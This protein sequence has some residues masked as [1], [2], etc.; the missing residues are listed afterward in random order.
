MGEVSDADVFQV[1][2]IIPNRV[3]FCPCHEDPSSTDEVLRFTIDMDSFYS[4]H[5]FLNEF[6]PPSIAQVHKFFDMLYYLLEDRPELIHYFCYDDAYKFTTA[7]CLICTFQMIYTGLSAEQVFNPFRHLEPCFMPFSDASNLPQTHIL[8]VENYLKGFER[9]LRLGWYHP[10]YFDPDDWEWLSQ[11][12]HGEISWIV[13]GKLLAFASPWTE[14]EV[15]EGYSVCVVSDMIDLLKEMGITHVIRLNEKVY[16]ETEFKNAGFKHTDLYFPDGTAPPVTVKDAWLR[17][18]NSDDVVALHCEA[19][20][21]GAATLAGVYLIKRYGFSGDEA[22]GWIRLCRPGSVVG[23][24]QKYLA[25]YKARECPTLLQMRR[26]SR[27]IK[28]PS[29]S[30]KKA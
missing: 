24:Q 17:I 19:G 13:P 8:T 26:G 4:Y 10:S 15:S 21:G 12:D 28:R 1:I 9:G 30:P 27:S 5:R 14:K 3:I 23:P 6:G 7:V 29:L 2:E 25:E 20:R 11:T 16:D 18:I 22:I